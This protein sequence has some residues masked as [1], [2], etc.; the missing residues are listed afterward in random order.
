LTLDR[1]QKPRRP[2]E[3][4]GEKVAMRSREGRIQIQ[5]CRFGATQG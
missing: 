1:K 5:R 2:G 4:R 3:R